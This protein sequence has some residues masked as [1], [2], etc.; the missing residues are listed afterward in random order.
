MKNTGDLQGQNENKCGNLFEF[1]TK[2]KFKLVLNSYVFK[3]S[4]FTRWI[5]LPIKTCLTTIQNKEHKYFYRNKVIDAC[6]KVQQALD[7]SQFS[8]Q[9]SFVPVK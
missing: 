6:V 8:L 5:K 2:A 3:L 9:L 7:D 1:I 4:K